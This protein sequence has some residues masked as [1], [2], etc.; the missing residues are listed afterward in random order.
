M[1][2]EKDIIIHEGVFSYD[3]KGAI[4][5]MH[6]TYDIEKIKA[7]MLPIDEVTE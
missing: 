4:L 7:K 5:N 2:D 1:T 6:S 3:G